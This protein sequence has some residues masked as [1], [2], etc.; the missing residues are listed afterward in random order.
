MNSLPFRS[1]KCS[2][3]Q[4]STAL[5]TSVDTPRLDMADS[6]NQTGPSINVNGLNYKFQDGS[7]GLTN[8]T[9]SL[10]A[11]SRTLLIGGDLVPS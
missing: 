1:S 7:S 2:S 4:G 9:L 6:G 5:T 11:G 3:H 10:P 8:V